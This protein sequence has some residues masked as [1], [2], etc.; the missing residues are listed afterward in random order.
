MKGTLKNHTKVF[1]HVS[2]DIW[3][4]SIILGPCAFFFFLQG[5]EWSSQ[6]EC[7]MHAYRFTLQ[8]WLEAK[9]A[10][11]N[12]T[13]QVGTFQSHYKLSFIPI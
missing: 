9:L 2:V 8:V 10:N 12:N 11:C 1:P 7:V 5:M 13:V 6:D 3:E 4:F